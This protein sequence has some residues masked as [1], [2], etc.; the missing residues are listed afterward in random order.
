MNIP[1]IVLAVGL[2][3]S[4]KS[5]WF[6]NEGV[7]PL[8]SDA[9][10]ALLF[11][12]EVDQR[13]HRVVF[14]T[15]RALLRRRLELKRPVT[16]VDATHLS[17]WERSPYLALARLYECEVEALWFDEPLEVCLQRNSS[18]SRVVPPAAIRRMHERMEAPTLAEGFSRIT[19]VRQGRVCGVLPETLQDKPEG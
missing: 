10:R 16:Y 4:G 2:P 7:T 5:T 8:S 9:I 18:R 12:S 13:N 17:R 1:R 11:D 14:A 3:A 6:A 19:V 15:M